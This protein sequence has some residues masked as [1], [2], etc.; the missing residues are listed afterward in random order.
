MPYS[1]ECFGNVKEDCSR[2]EFPRESL[3]AFFNDSQDLMRGRVMFL[4]PKLLVGDDVV[5][6]GE[7]L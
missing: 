3:V 2:G 7:F 6:G 4:E 5:I 1:V